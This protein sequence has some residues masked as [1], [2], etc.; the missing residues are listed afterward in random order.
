MRFPKRIE[1]LY[2]PAQ[3]DAEAH[4][5]ALTKTLIR[6]RMGSAWWDDPAI[7][8]RAAAD[9][10]DRGWDWT[11]EEI[12]RNGRVLKSRKLAVVTG[13]R[14]VQGAMLAS[15]EPVACE[16]ESGQSAL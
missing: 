4:V 13:D 15:T 8:S 10:I 5:V 14:A 3:T 7:D 6:R 9:E 11:T 1:L 12:E 2:V 16:R